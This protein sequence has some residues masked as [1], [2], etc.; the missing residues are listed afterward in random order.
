VG[1]IDGSYRLKTDN[2]LEEIKIIGELIGKY[3]VPIILCIVLLYIFINDWLRNQKE[4]MK[5]IQIITDILY[6]ILEALKIRNGD[7]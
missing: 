5:K 3:G 4:E 1:F 2:I 7:K 6:R